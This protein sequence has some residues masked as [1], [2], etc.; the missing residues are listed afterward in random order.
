VA[1]GAVLCVVALGGCRYGF[2][3]GGLPSDIKTAAVLPFENETI[4]AELPL[5][6]AEALREGL[7]R[8]LGLRAST[9]E[10]ADMVVQGKIRRYE[11]DVAV[12]VSAD[13]QNTTA[14]RKLTIGIDIQLVSQ[15]TGVV[16]WQKT[17]LVADGDYAERAEADGRK[18]AIERIVADVIEGAQSQ[19]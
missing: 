4:S 3:G 19:W 15:R 1:V 12:A 6:L 16:L 5:E 18:L 13:R 2:L 17:G 10:K 8:R 14:R 11:A 9:E 7:E